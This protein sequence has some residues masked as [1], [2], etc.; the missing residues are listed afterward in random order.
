[1]RLKVFILL[2]GLTMSSFTKAIAQEGNIWCFGSGVGL[3]FNSGNPVAFTTAMQFGSPCASVADEQ[4]NLLFYTNGVQVWN[5]QHQ[6]MPNGNDLIV[7][8]VLPPPAQ[9]N[10]PHATNYISNGSNP[11]AVMIVPMPEQKNLYY[12][13]LLTNVN[14]FPWDG[15]LYY[16]I[17]NMDL[18]G[19]LGDVDGECRLLDV[20]LISRGTIYQEGPL[21]GVVGD[22]C[23][24]W[25]L[26]TKHNQS[27]NFLAAYNID[28][29]GIDSLPVLSNINIPG[30]SNFR[31]GSQFVVAPNR[32]K[33]AFAANA[34][35]FDFDPFTGIA[36]NGLS[37]SSTDENPCGYFNVA[38]SSDNAKL[39]CSGGMFNSCRLDQYD[40]NS[41]D[42]ALMASSRTLIANEGGNLRLGPDGRIYI[43]NQTL[44]SPV[45]YG[46]I[47]KP[48]LSGVACDF[49]PNTPI[50][51]P[52]TGSNGHALPTVVPVI[53]NR[54]TLYGTQ[55]DSAVA[56]AEKPK[57]LLRASEQDGWG[58][59]WDDG[60]IGPQRVVADSGT[61]W[62]Q[63]FDR[64]CKF[65]IDTFKI[66]YYGLPEQ[67]LGPDLSFCEGDLI[68]VNLTANVSQEAA[69][70][71]STGQTTS[72]I[73]A[74]DT[75]SYWVNVAVAPCVS[76]DSMYI[77]LEHC[78]CFFNMPNAF[79][80]NAD[81]LNDV[82]MASIETACPM[83]SNYSLSIYN[84]YG[85][86]IYKSV[87]PGQGW[88]GTLNGRPADVGTYFYEFQFTGGTKGESYYRKGDFVLMR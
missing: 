18:D 74:S 78:E 9:L 44:G 24:V 62:V 17:V 58:Y 19:G 53:K 86:R 29:D 68:A 83:I 1:M 42:S 52:G 16:R 5:R 85:Q 77:G 31:S 70:F 28:G 37:L 64:P 65:Y 72:S 7:D 79:S 26:A 57:T 3:D 10:P 82:F 23:N 69:V 54:D 27:G 45:L 22:R 43:S 55:T 50:F 33:I 49:M 61:Y 13:F 14:M 66:S 75:G 20:S 63:Y 38:F 88:D 80:P 39:Y 81:G 2:A 11:G 67:D 15:R 40:L 36:S 51:S 32:K 87:S 12:I 73:T 30:R 25:L 34:T 60:S 48:N 46:V 35:L 8:P 21:T 59:I 6:V 41:G 47:D 56:C 4:G 71:W 76:V 84:R